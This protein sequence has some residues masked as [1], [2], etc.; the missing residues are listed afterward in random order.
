M[1][2]GWTLSGLTV[3]DL[4]KIILNS[5]GGPLT[6]LV[7]RGA[8][9]FPLVLTPQLGCSYPIESVFNDRFNAFADGNRIVIY[10][11]LFSHVP[12][13]REVAVIVGHE[14]AHN[15]LR[16][17]E[18]K[19]GNAAAGGAAGL[20][21]DIGLLALGVNTQ[22]AISRAGVEAGAL[23][24]SQEFE[25]E[26]DYLGLYMLARAGFDIDV[27]PDLFRRR[28]VQNPSTQVKTYYS[29][30]LSTPERAAAM[31]QTIG[32]INQKRSSQTALLPS[33]LPG[34]TLEVRAQPVSSPPV[35]VAAQTPTAAAAVPGPGTAFAPVAPALH[36]ATIPSSAPPPPIRS[37][38]SKTLAQLFLVRGPVVTN[39]PQTFSA[40]FSDDGKASAI[41]SGRR[42][43]T[44][45]YE[46]V[47]LSD[48][49]KAKYSP[50]LVNTD[51]IKPLG[52]A[53]A[54]GFAVLSDGRG[55]DLECAYYFNRSTRQGEGTCADNQRNTYTL[56]FD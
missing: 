25:S 53:D 11:G 9:I 41:L 40:E 45:N 50:R 33:T 54:K 18:K 22:G 10:T 24:Y 43:I 23:A 52:S 4:A 8:N 19:Q 48:S 20:I 42:L 30:H 51:S 17:P 34:Q 36:S 14:L 6:L 29:T 7:R 15:V 16:H 1:P 46:L 47:E 39:P 5:E 28:A 37:S 27:A 44:G 31:T 3:Q 38:G 56:L 12:D 21:V 35:V 55:T 49:I 32:E 26:A 13:D 2:S